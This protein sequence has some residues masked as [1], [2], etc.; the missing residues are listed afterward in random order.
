MSA[1]PRGFRPMPAQVD[2]PALEHDV[3]E[4]WQQRNVFA[5]SLAATAD[6]Q[7]WTFY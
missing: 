6:G 4:R 1:E 2:L 7:L 5:R 3:L